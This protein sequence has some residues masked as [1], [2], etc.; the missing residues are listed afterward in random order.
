MPY[1]NEED[2]KDP[3]NNIHPDDLDSHLLEAGTWLFHHKR[4]HM[5]ELTWSVHKDTKRL[6]R[7]GSGDS[8]E[9]WFLLNDGMTDTIAFEMNY[10][11]LICATRNLWTR[12]SC[13]PM[14][15][16]ISAQATELHSLWGVDQNPDKS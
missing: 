11:S 12:I 4:W 1:I 9:F 14:G 2:C 8:P 15:G 10:N 13:I 3:F 6:D 7:A 16:S 5:K